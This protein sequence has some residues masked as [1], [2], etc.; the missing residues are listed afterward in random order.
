MIFH[1]RIHYPLP[2]EYTG[3]PDP[4]ILQSQIKRLEDEV[5][6]LKTDLLAKGNKNETK[7]LAA[8]Q[9]R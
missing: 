7:M 2:L 1:S 5:A 6:R 9:E 4:M 3:Q 8:L